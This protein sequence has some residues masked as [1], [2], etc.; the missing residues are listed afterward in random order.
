MINLFQRFTDNGGA[1]FILQEINR[2]LSGK[3][4]VRPIQPGL[5]L[6]LIAEYP[7]GERHDLKESGKSA[8]VRIEAADQAEE[9]LPDNAA[10]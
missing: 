5:G 8:I 7:V 1:E 6:L 4:R 9:T 3:R 2:L 10:R